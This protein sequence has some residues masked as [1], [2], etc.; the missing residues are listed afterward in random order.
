MPRETQ[1][2]IRVS[3]EE[4]EAMEAR[5]RSERL[6]LTAWLRRLALLDV[7]RGAKEEVRA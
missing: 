7:E 4:K 1:V 2:Q 5:A 6:S 3:K